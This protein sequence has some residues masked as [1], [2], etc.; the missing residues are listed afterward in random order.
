MS[1]KFHVGQKVI[2][3]V[4]WKCTNKIWKGQAIQKDEVHV[5]REIAF[6]TCGCGISGL[7][8]EGIINP[9]IDGQELGYDKSEFEPL[10]ETT[11]QFV[12]VTFT[13]IIETAPK[14]CAS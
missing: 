9:L 12:E 4:P 11:Q 1:H 5:I 6:C 8:F 10:I 3:I 13:K 7:R 2:R 14:T